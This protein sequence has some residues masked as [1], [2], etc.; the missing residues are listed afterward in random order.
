LVRKYRR[1]CGNPSPWRSLTLET[2]RIKS[3]QIVEVGSSET[4]DFRV[5]HNVTEE[6]IPPRPR[7]GGYFNL[8]ALLLQKKGTFFNQ[9]NR[10]RDYYDDSENIGESMKYK[11]FGLTCTVDVYRDGWMRQCRKPAVGT[12]NS[13]VKPIEVC[14]EHAKDFEKK[15]VKVHYYDIIDDKVGEKKSMKYK[16]INPIREDSFIE[17]EDITFEDDS[18]INDIFPDEGLDNQTGQQ[19]QFDYAM[20]PQENKEEIDIDGLLGEEP[21]QPSV[22]EAKKRRSFGMKSIKVKELIETCVERK[23][24]KPQ[25]MEVLQYHGFLK[26]GA[27]DSE[28]YDVGSIMDYEGGEQEDN[29]TVAMFQKMIDNGSVWRLQGSYGR[30]AMELIKSG[31]CILGPEGFHDYWG[32]YI[33]SRFEVKPGTKGSVEYQKKMLGENSINSKIPLHEKIYIV[34]DE[35]GEEVVDPKTGESLYIR[36]NNHNE[37]EKKAKAKYGPR[38]SVCYTEI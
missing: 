32:N 20:P 13:A 12:V 15:G 28:E 37:A 4:K 19:T 38:A 31:Q 9:N 14:E 2:T 16:N 11:N 24:T 36:A 23:L 30:Q 33:P 27:Y 21:T 1:D 7:T 34:Y 6:N 5:V 29:D 26:E 22:W 35:R 8:E 25:I 10:D 18:F 3:C 17:P